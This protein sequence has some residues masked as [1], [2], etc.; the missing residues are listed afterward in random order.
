MPYHDNH[1][2]LENYFSEY[3][4]KHGEELLLVEINE[5]RKFRG[6]DSVLKSDF[7]ARKRLG[8][9]LPGRDRLTPFV[10]SLA[11]Y[12][13]YLVWQPTWFDPNEKL[14]YSGVVT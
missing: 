2:Y 7:D 12:A 10:G 13:T 5:A 6:A 11:Q 8:C 4:A 3:L 14:A 1:E 9:E